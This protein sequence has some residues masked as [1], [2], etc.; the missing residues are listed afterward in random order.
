MLVLLF[1][2]LLAFFGL[3]WREVHCFL[4]GRADGNEQRDQQSQLQVPGG[5]ANRDDYQEEEAA[6]A[7]RSNDP[8][9]RQMEDNYKAQMA[10]RP[11]QPRPATDGGQGP[12]K[13]TGADARTRANKEKNKAHAGNHNRKDRGEWKRREF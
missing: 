5:R 9:V 7:P 10:R 8:W 6:P 13:A 12:G 2:L 1:C 3:V 11:A 4:L